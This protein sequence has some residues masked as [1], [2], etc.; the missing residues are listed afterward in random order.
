MDS[1][2]LFVQFQLEIG[3]FGFTRPGTSDMP[4]LTSA[5]HGTPGYRAPELLGDNEGRYTIWAVG[6]ILF[7]LVTKEQ[8]FKTDFAVKEYTYCQS[9]LSIPFYRKIEN[10]VKTTAL[11]HSR[12]VKREP[13]DSSVQRQSSQ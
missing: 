1:A 9:D 8:A 13:V 4:L 6:C 11:C 5:G 10:P 7:E 3:T 12:N 2:F